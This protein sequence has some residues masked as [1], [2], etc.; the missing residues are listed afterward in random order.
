MGHRYLQGF[1]FS[2]PLER[3]QLL[4]GAWRVGAAVSTPAL[5]APRP[6]EPPLT[7]AVLR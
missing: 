7:P 2:R 1:L 6:A 4:E 5:P 3:A